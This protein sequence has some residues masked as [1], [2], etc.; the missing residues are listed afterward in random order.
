M[1][2]EVV[3]I[4]AELSLDAF[5]D[6]ERLANCHVVEEGIRS[7]I[8]IEADVAD[9]TARGQRERTGGRTS[10]LALV[11]EAGKV[12]RRV[13]D[14]GQRLAQRGNR[15]KPVRAVSAAGIRR[16]TRRGS[17]AGA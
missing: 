7:A 12:D 9:L 15:S 8:G 16:I 2:E 11:V 6:R 17:F 14:V 4:E 5:G 10:S 13:G 1:V 3:S